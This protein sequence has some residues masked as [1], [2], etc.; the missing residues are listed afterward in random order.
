MK[1]VVL[2]AMKGNMWKMKGN[3]IKALQKSGGTPTDLKKHATDNFYNVQVIKHD[4][5][6]D[7]VMKN[8][9]RFEYENSLKSWGFFIYE[10]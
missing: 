2:P 1:L 10:G 3:T 5:M 9:T 7:N 6:F 4:I 8:L